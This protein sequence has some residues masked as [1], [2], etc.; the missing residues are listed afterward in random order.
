MK[1]EVW[2][3]VMRRLGAAV[4]AFSLAFPAAAFAG[5]RG[6]QKK[7]EI[8]SYYGEEG[9]KAKGWLKIENQWYY[10]DPANGEMR[11]GWFQD[12]GGSWYFLN[13]T[14]GSENG[15][16]L[17]GWQW[18]DGYCYYLGTADSGKMLA[19]GKT[20]DGF[21][22][23]AEGRWINEQG[24]AE[25]VEGK[26]YITKK[27]PGKSVKA[28][29]KSSGSGDGGSS[30][31]GRGRK[32]DSQKE[33]EQDQK[34]P[35]GDAQSGT[36]DE[37]E[38]QKPKAQDET[39]G[40]LPEKKQDD[41]PGNN[42]NEG[43]GKQEDIPDQGRE[44]W[45]TVADYSKSN[46]LSVK[47]TNEE[48]LAAIQEKAYRLFNTEEERQNLYFLELADQV[49]IVDLNDKLLGKESGEITADVENKIYL[50]TEDNLLEEASEERLGDTQNVKKLMLLS[51]S[52]T[53]SI[54]PAAEYTLGLPGSRYNGSLAVLDP[55]KEVAGIRFISK[56]S[57]VARGANGAMISLKSERDDF[58]CSIDHNSFYFSDQDTET[59]LYRAVGIYSFAGK[60]EIIGNT[61]EGHNRKNGIGTS[62]SHAAIDCQ[63]RSKKKNSFIMIRDNRF[64][65][66]YSAGIILYASEKEAVHIENN[67]FAGTGEEAIK[68]TPAVVEYPQEHDILIRGNTISRYG[69]NENTGYTEGGFGG[70]G[71]VNTGEFGIHLSFYG[72][73]QRGS[74]VNG[75]WHSSADQLSRRLK[76]E[77][78]ISPKAENDANAGVV[79]SAQ[80]LIG[81][82][83]LY[84]DTASAINRSESSLIKNKSLVIVK[85]ENKDIVYGQDPENISA[86]IKVKDLYICGEGA[87]VVTLPSTLH[88][89]GDL[90]VDLPNG[91]VKTEA[92]V[93][94]SST[95]NAG[96]V[97]S[98][99]VFTAL[100]GEPI[101][102]AAAE[103]DF[104]VKISQIRDDEGRDLEN[105][106]LN[107][108]VVLGKKE[109]SESEFEYKDGILRIKKELINGLEKSERLLIRISAPDQNL[110][111]VSSLPILIEISNLSSAS[112]EYSSKSFSHLDAEEEISV[113]LSAVKNQ[114]GE[115][116][117]PADT[118][119]EGNVDFLIFGQPQD[120]R[121]LSVDDA[122]DTIKI[123]KELLNYLY[124]TR[125]EASPERN[126][127]FG[128]S[129]SYEIRINDPS[130]HIYEVRDSVSFEVRDRSG[131]DFVFEKGM[132]F[133]QGQAPEEGITLSVKDVVNTRGERVDP[134]RTRLQ[135]EKGN[136]NMNV[137]PFP[138][139]RDQS[140]NSEIIVIRDENG[141]YLREVFNP[142]YIRIDDEKDTITFTKEYLDKI[143]P[144]KDSS[145]ENG[146]KTFVFKYTDTFAKVDVRSQKVALHIKL[147][148]KELS[149]DT[150]ISFKENTYRIEGERIIG[151]E[152]SHPGSLMLAGFLKHVIK[153]NP[154]Q[155]II[156]SREGKIL[157]AFDALYRGDKIRIIAEDGVS[158]AV[159]TFD[160]E[161]KYGEKLYQSFD[162]SLIGEFGES[163]IMVRKEDSLS[164]R[165]FLA[166]IVLGEGTKARVL[167]PDGN[168]G[169]YEPVIDSTLTGDMVL[170][171]GRGDQEQRFMIR[172]SD[173][174][175]YRALLIG[176]QNYG[177]PKANLAGPE[178]D[179]KIMNSLFKRAS[180]GGKSFEKIQTEKDLNKEAFL[181]KIAEAFAGATDEDV[182]Y[183]YYSGHGYHI[184]S[185]NSSYICT[186]DAIPER[187]AEEDSAAH[188]VSVDELKHALDRIPGTKVV[189]LDCCNAG[190][191]IGKEF[192]DATSGATPRLD[193]AE[194]AEGFVSSAA[195]LFE[196]TEG[197][198][199]YLT[200]GEYK[201]L[202]ASS[203]N[204]YSYEDK[205]KA[206]GKFTVEFVKGVQEGLADADK[207][208]QISLDEMYAYLMENVESISHIQVF[209]QK[210]AFC[211]IERVS[212]SELNA[213]L[214]FKIKNSAY[215]FESRDLGGG[216][217][218][219]TIK[220]NLKE[221]NENTRASEFLQNIEKEHESQS[222]ALET[223]GGREYASEE[224]LRRADAYL[225]VSAENGKTA[226]Y[227]LV[228][229][230]VISDDEQKSVVIK[231]APEKGIRVSVDES[232]S[233]YAISLDRPMTVIE[234]IT[235]IRRANL[236]PM[237]YYKLFAK[238]GEEKKMNKT[239]YVA[240][241]D[242]LEVSSPDKT[243]KQI[244]NI[245]VN[246]EAGNEAEG[247]YKVEQNVIKSGGKKLTKETKVSELLDWLRKNQ[248][249]LDADRMSG[250]YPAG[251]TP[252]FGRK[253]TGNQ[254][255]AEG[256]RLIIRDFMGYTKQIYTIEL[257]EEGSETTN[258]DQGE[259]TQFEALQP[260]FQSMLK[261]EGDVI[262]SG[263]LKLGPDTK[264]KEVL[265]AWT[266]QEEMAGLIDLERSGIYKGAAQIIGGNPNKPAKT[267]EETIGYG[268]RLIIFGKS[269]SGK[270]KAYRLEL[271][272]EGGGDGPIVI[273]PIVIGSEELSETAADLPE[274]IGAEDLQKEKP[275]E[276]NPE[277]LDPEAANPE[278]FGSE[279]PK[280]ES[281]KPE[282]VNPEAL[283]SQ[284]KP[285]KEELKEESEPENPQEEEG[286]EDLEI[287]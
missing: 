18:I 252:P 148:E 228:V 171:L 279:V 225:K 38:L 49:L 248:F 218:V 98:S 174:T 114:K 287:R 100:S 103:S 76:E 69:L 21:S 194:E 175:Q 214:L 133:T 119:L 158:E 53:R 83:G 104:E 127:N 50:S 81:Q 237:K 168:G 87:G 234:F 68:L 12:A 178:N 203:S 272:D 86:E 261:L 275:E 286:F 139:H 280:P 126:A 284:Q 219:G 173:G 188:W 116:V 95:I 235:T 156:A 229:E 281:F 266:N 108:S 211:L 89:T 270:Y 160:I 283:N 113:R 141:N 191:F 74:K 24:K 215:S 97:K 226:R 260:D 161:T 33:K 94:K 267:G 36:S 238:N 172:F 253:K 91:F 154:R 80:V 129:Q 183:L 35:Q 185:R 193:A 37:K 282:E 102:R 42:P 249:D 71:P 140:E 239:S 208:A 157:R 204:E 123:S 110:S 27:N 224:K 45:M 26:G 128:T 30:G 273:P 232:A 182:S 163:F 4:C 16:M 258:P 196:N 198:K 92:R 285:K 20:P 61:F 3:T 111:T 109:L 121:L 165:R 19:S 85:E 209:P 46:I 223:Q 22:V 120:K 52:H 256:D 55:C 276:V 216:K 47:K 263:S 44:G 144:G 135:D 62:N 166:A 187:S 67:F 236:K 242:K 134:S 13:P 39:P 143:H 7:G 51:G 88:I 241:L 233:L 84:L 245:T 151:A 255:L 32:E 112:F 197:N 131:A 54:L 149:K 186:V 146:I 274:K 177:N 246:S 142:K 176:N 190:G 99:A 78:T 63:A 213:S 75:A 25:F 106:K 231:G 201:V 217:I 265:G 56:S 79:D 240:S 207:N 169:E 210:D 40:T 254:T 180:F 147:K 277:S 137:E 145:T 155:R 57:K 221:I 199:N 70:L 107:L 125:Y 251:M 23:N 82:K 262:K 90:R 17:F 192:T 43:G 6:W 220:G 162:E 212:A 66:L 1:K 170:V 124:A 132:T 227:P 152:G 58:S 138:V 14:E 96:R 9:I 195:M 15:K 181:A 184:K 65:D 205:K 257:A 5:S 206:I 164:I 130:H 230:K 150:E 60:L 136:L 259:E 268:D 278:L 118:K 59:E 159:Y 34:T 41:F 179:I 200:D 105:P 202:V 153:K 243:V 73:T 222:I 29:A 101:P 28:G 10:F 93:D 264:V 167:S 2:K 122:S 271:E 250:I 72:G 247:D 48:N 8:W 117:A 31:S 64:T 77:N 11:T 189:I 269:G 244:Y 115:P